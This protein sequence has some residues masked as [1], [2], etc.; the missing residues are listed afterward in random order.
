MIPKNIKREHVIK[1][2]E[3]VKKSGVPKTRRSRKFLLTF[4]GKTYPP[5]YIISLANK[6]ANGVE[7]DPSEFSGGRETNE[8]LRALGFKIVEVAGKTDK[9]PS[10]R[11]EIKPPENRHNERC[12]KCKETIR[13]LLERIYGKVEENY[14]FEAGT[15]PEDYRDTPYYSK[16]KEIYKALQNHRGFKNF[17]KTKTLPHCDFFVPDPGFILE[18]DES[19]HFTQPRRITLEKYPDSLRLGFSRKK[20]IM[21]CKKINS[22]DNN[23]PYRD[24]QRAWY[25][26]LRDFLPAVFGLKPTV[27]LFARDFV[28]CSLDPENPSDV[29]R[30]ENILKRA[31][32]TWEIEIREEE[33]P[34]LGRVI[35]AGEWKGEPEEAKRLLEDV[36]DRWPK[37]RRVKF[38]ITCG[39]FIQ[40]KWPEA[41]SKEDI[42]DNKNPNPAAVNALVAEAEKYVSL[43]LS[44]ELRDKLVKITDYITLG[45]DSYKE[46]ISTT[47][48]YI[49]RPHVELVFLVDLRSNK[50]YWTGKSYPTF[51]QQNGLVRIVDLRTHFIDLDIGKI[52]VLGCHDLTIFNPRS[53]NAKGWRKRINEEFKELARKEKPVCVLHHPHTTVKVRT[54]LNAWNN[55]RR[56]LPSVKVY[57]GAGRFHEPDRDPSEYDKLDD[58]LRYT[59]NVNTIDAVIF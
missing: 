6:Y 20:W 59:K 32:Q 43:V 11:G 58:V 26:T 53:K 55:L 34:F 50:F 52:M 39:G 40:F 5:K 54:W 21:L 28:W 3:E 4:E 18:L 12:K 41:V 13:R 42:G 47:K 27:R 24:E 9:Q 33:K 2:I 57:A 15:H 38:L 16:L 22:K 19:Q 36:C 31:A 45:V 46:R 44:K 35:I 10:K 7:L 51:S 56:I 30:F 48:N 49:S 14:R 17:V 8:F 29:K 23:P 37:N 1:A 25:D